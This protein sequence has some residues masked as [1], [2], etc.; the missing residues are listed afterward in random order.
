[1]RRALPI[2]LLVTITALVYANTLRNGFHLD[3]FYRIVENPEIRRL[4]P[5]WRHFTD[6]AT[7]SGSQGTSETRLH[8]LAQYR[9]LLPL[10][11]AVNHAVAGHSLI[12]YHL[13]NLLFHTAASVVVYLL[14][15]EL[16]RFRSP[17]AVEGTRER[18]LGLA[19]AG[20]FA[21]HPVS[22]IPVNYIL[23]RDLLL[24]EFFLMGSLLA[25][26][27]MRREGDTSWRWIVALGFLILALLSKAT[28]AMAPL[29]VLVFEATMGRGSLR[30]AAPWLR[31]APFVA[32]VAGF[33]GFAALVLDFSA[34]AQV[35]QGGPPFWWYPL[36][37]ATVHL[38]HYLTNFFWPFPIRMAAAVEPARGLLE[39]QVLL[40]LAVIGA[41][42]FAA[43]RVRRTAPILAFSIAGYWVLMAPESSILPLHH[44]AVHYRPYPAS[45]F[46]FLALG[47]VIER[48]VPSRA[49]A[50]IGAA[51]IAF[52]AG[53]S[54]SLNRTWRSEE[55]LWTH[56][57]RYGAEPLAHM[58]LA[59]S[60][61]DRS[62]PRVRL[63][64]EEALRMSPDYVL[65][66]VNLG[67]LD[68]HQGRQEE[69]LERLRRA[70][71]MNPS[72]GQPQYWLSEA[73]SWLGR[74]EEAAI[75]S[76]RAASLD[77]RNRRFLY[78]A[79][80]DASRLNDHPATL[81]FVERLERFDPDYE[82]VGFLEGYSLQ[83]QG[84]LDDAV[85]AYLVFLVRHP[86]HP[87]VHFNL[88]HALM[89]SG[90]CREAVPHFEETLR[91]KPGYEGAR[92]HLATC[93]GGATQMGPGELGL[94]SRYR[95][96]MDA[97]RAGE[98]ARSLDIIRSVEAVRP[99]YE[100]TL[101]L[102]GF[103]LHMLGRL[104]EAVVAYRSF[105]ARHP[106]HAQVYFNLG[107]ALM[108]TG[109]CDLAIP[110]LEQSLAI[111]PGR[112]AAHVHL[113]DCFD[114]LGDPRSAERHRRL[115]RP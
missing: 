53:A 88:G 36:T 1:M 2:L 41:A 90:R 26:V 56:S 43:W 9:P 110:P 61:A 16:L 60:I 23:A 99:D 89:S 113:G 48:W 33:Y 38:F 19:V 12:G 67:L 34:L 69:G 73:Y 94:A 42:F 75:A 17:G 14:V 91:L 11:L 27:R 78:K 101:F 62:D 28:A 111:E 59:M 22:G 25:Y 109:R 4:S 65:A 87:Q 21:V 85:K 71:H 54:V 44:L 39:P 103:D 10:T 20:A 112:L 115:S 6:P 105:L 31:T 66:H 81:G 13:G 8:Q 92:Q 74:H 51:A 84:R 50:A 107:H 80:L 3:D 100:E 98:Y 102:K 24:M 64:L 72:Q 58:N 93:R 47:L 29:L 49:A 106:G 37:Q 95:A 108:S 5:I 46:F 68:V 79:A 30:M 52:F 7:I 104:A 32:V 77:S 97:Y 83:M 63:H 76:A 15:L 45:P 82:E 35:Q 40:G 18:L 57:V 86:D 96:A 70:A 55:T 114:R